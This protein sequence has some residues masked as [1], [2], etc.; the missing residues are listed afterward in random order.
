MPSDIATQ[1]ALTG[2]KINRVAVDK[3]PSPLTLDNLDQLNAL[4]GKDIWLTSHEG[5]QANP[6]WFFGVAPDDNHKTTGLTS[7]AIVTVDKGNATVDAF[8]FYFYAYN[9]GNQVLG[10]EFGDHVGDWEHNM[11]RFRDGAPQAMYFSQHA[12]AQTF[13]YKAVEKMGKRPVVYVA[14]GSH[15]VYGTAGYVHSHTL[16][17]DFS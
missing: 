5:I 12:S 8:Y 4:G 9:Q 2:P 16:S 15:A 7:C 17:H 6:K 14:K 11:I 3:A 13:T 10:M 1:V